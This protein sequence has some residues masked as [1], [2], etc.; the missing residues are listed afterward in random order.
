MNKTKAA[1]F[2]LIS[3]LSWFYQ[4]TAN[5][6]DLT[7][8]SHS[9]LHVGAGQPS[10]AVCDFNTDGDLDVIFANYSD[11]NI[12]AFKGNGKGDLQE[13]GRFSVGENPTS[14]DVADINDDGN[15][16]IAIANHET[17]YVTL[18]LGDGE[19]DFKTTPHSVFQTDLSPHPH[20]VRLEDLDGDN[21]VDLVVDSR[22]HNGLRFY[23]GRANGRFE[24]KS[25]LINTGGDPY[26]GFAINHINADDLLDVVT[27]NEDG[28]GV[29]NNTSSDTLSFTLKTLTPYEDPFAVE[30]AKM[31][32]DGK[33][34]L[35]VASNGASI[36]I[37]PGDGN[38]DFREE[39]KIQIKTASGAKQ[40]AIGDI[41][42]DGMKDALISNWSG[43]LYA[44][45]G[46]MAKIEV[47]SFELPNIPNPWGVALADLNK[48]G[49]SDL[50]VADGSS[51]L[52]A[53]Y[54]SN[55]EK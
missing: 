29:V 3:S 9:L 23:K 12:I 15:V 54:I 5:E 16:D 11:N 18:L 30:L 32:G 44:V 49:K 51:K 39:S 25:Q 40:I 14:I 21:K 34:D 53:V 4:A 2:F 10:I 6:I 13:S 28:I 43:E 19:G 31:N 8:Y 38:G 1:L 36:V 52:A 27:P 47:S 42:G 46:G 45:F 55:Q 22:T 33:M 26:R 48:D 20:L 50:I 7:E 37:V 24:S 35:I 17:S 41:D